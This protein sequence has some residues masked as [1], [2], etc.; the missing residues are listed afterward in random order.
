MLAEFKDYLKTLEVAEEYYIGK[1]DNSKLE[2]VGIYSTPYGL[3]R[4]EAV[5]KESDYDVAGVRILV[6]WNKNA[7]ETEQ[8]AR[9]I[10]EAIRYINQVQ[11]GSIYVYLVDVVDAEPNFIGTDDNGVYEYHIEARIYYRR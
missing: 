8:A 5:G 10:F 4:V 6:H 3:R 11:M 1:L 2:A 7:K 9:D